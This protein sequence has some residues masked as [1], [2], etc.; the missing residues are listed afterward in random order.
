MLR[1][2][3][4]VA[5]EDP[6]CALNVRWYDASRAPVG[7]LQTKYDSA[8]FRAHFY[9]HTPLPDALIHIVQEYYG[10]PGLCPF[11][12]N[13]T[14]TVA[15]AAQLA[16]VYGTGEERRRRTIGAPAPRPHAQQ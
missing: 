9:A 1:A 16:A 8:V 7:A 6:R 15:T 5:Q 3:W 13:I 14:E 12:H 4:A 10:M 11:A 2:L